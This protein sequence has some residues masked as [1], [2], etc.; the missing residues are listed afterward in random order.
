MRVVTVA[1]DAVPASKP[2]SKGVEEVHWTCIEFVWS[3]FAVR[4]PFEPKSKFA[5]FRIVQLATIV[6][7]LWHVDVVV[8]AEA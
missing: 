3:T 7:W 6:T 4:M 2:I 8:V 1:P 5:A